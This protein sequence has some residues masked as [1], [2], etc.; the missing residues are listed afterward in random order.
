MWDKVVF[1]FHPS[2]EEFDGSVDDK[3]RYVQLLS[4]CSEVVEGSGQRYLSVSPPDDVNDS[5]LSPG[6]S[7]FT[8]RGG[9]VGLSEHF[10]WE[11]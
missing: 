2:D 9:H 7:L 11:L 10:S 5:V 1:Y 4:E 6:K 8:R 3:N